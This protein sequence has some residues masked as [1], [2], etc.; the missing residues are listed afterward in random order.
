MI[1]DEKLAMDLR[2]LKESDSLQINGSVYRVVSVE[3]LPAPRPDGKSEVKDGGM[4]LELK[5][6]AGSFFSLVLTDN[7]VCYTLERVL[8]GPAPLN[9]NMDILFDQ[10]ND[11]TFKYRISR[12]RKK[13]MILA[14]FEGETEIGMDSIQL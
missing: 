3:E 11:K 2:A 13:K 12:R 8:G 5:N 4:R 7:E 14:F 9:S 6:G 1:I 10:I